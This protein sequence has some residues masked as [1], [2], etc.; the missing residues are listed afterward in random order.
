MR[1]M[2]IDDGVELAQLMADVKAAG[3]DHVAGHVAARS[4]ADRRSRRLARRLARTL[5]Y[6]DIYAPNL[7]ET[8]FM[9]DRPRYDSPGRRDPGFARRRAAAHALRP[10]AGH[11][12]RHR[13]PQAGRPRPLSAHDRQPG[14]LAALA[15]LL[16]ADL[17]GWVGRELYTPCF[18]VKV[19]G[20][21]GAGDCA[22]AGLLA[23]LLYGQSVE[24][25]R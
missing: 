1:R 21:T 7:E 12:R 17:T 14:R 18:Q 8:L 25:V 3:V 2:H 9:I 20:T 16:P 22:Y 4:R 24:A 11:G 13:R 10:A 5:P 15:G 23:G 6:V 19:A